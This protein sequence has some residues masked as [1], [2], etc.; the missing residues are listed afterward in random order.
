VSGLK[1]NFHKSKLYGVNLDD[2]FLRASW[3]F[4]HCEVDSISFRFL[5]IPVGANPRHRA[6]WSPIQHVFFNCDVIVQV[7]D[8]IFKWLG[9]NFLVYTSVADHFL[10]FGGFI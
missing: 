6:T 2:C 1:V 9:I 8:Y 10:S 7:W 5:G 3:S 4:L